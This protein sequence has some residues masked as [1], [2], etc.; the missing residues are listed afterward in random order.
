MARASRAFPVGTRSIGSILEVEMNSDGGTP[1]FGQLTQPS[2]QPLSE[3]FNNLCKRMSAATGIHVG[4]FGIMSDNPSSAEAIYAEN[5][6]LILKCKSFIKQAKGAL[7]RVCTAALATEYGSD[8]DT[9]ERTFDV[10]G[11]FS[12]NPSMPTI[13]AADRFEHQACQRLRGFRGNAGF[14]A[15]ERLRR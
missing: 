12:L 13:G 9:A 15:L 8:Y 10:S 2:M 11:P 6:P 3:H 14:L 1:Q 4:Q 7:R 5:E